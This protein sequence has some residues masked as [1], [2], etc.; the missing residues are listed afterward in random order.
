[1]ELRASAGTGGSHG[2]L[3]L[4]ILR[5]RLKFNDLFHN[6][7]D[8]I[9]ANVAFSYVELFLRDIDQPRTQGRAFLFESGFRRWAIRQQNV[10]VGRRLMEFAGDADSLDKIA[11]LNVLVPRNDDERPALLRVLALRIGNRDLRINDP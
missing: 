2:F 8:K 6:L 10:M 7:L 9:S 5:D 3:T 11:S 4:E 1:M